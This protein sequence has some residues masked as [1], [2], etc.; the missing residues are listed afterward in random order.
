MAT[1]AVRDGMTS[2]L[3]YMSSGRCL[4]LQQQLVL[5]AAT[6]PATHSS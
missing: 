5:L 6:D 3:G 1:G 4:M 2:L